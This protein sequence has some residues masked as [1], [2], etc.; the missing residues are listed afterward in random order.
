MEVQG[1]DDDCSLTC[2]E[3]PWEACSIVADHGKRCDV[4][5]KSDGE[6]CKGVQRRH[7]R[8]L[9]QAVAKR[10]AAAASA[11][12][13]AAAADSEPP[14]KKARGAPPSRVPAAS[15]SAKRKKGKGGR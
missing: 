7:A 2:T 10:A 9:A 11:A 12:A 15:R 4:C 6:L 5:I 1:C 3:C 14:A 13:A 8:P